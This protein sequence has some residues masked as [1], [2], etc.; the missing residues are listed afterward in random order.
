MDKLDFLDSTTKTPAAPAA[1][2]LPPA[3]PLRPLLTSLS[4][5]QLP[6]ASVVCATCPSSLWH[7]TPT[8][9]R[10]YCGQMHSIVWA[11]S[12]PLPII[13]CDGLRIQRQ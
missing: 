4:P 2:I 13:G 6:P 3:P 10:C 8:E 12:Q 7:R 5:D 9:T 11:T 1:E